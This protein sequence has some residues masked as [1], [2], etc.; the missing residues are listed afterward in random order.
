MSVILGD[1]NIE[2][3]YVGSDDV[4][5]IYKGN[6]LI[7]DFTLTVPNEP[8]NVSINVEDIA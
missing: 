2:Q 8:T 1:Q 6:T 7:K 3:I 5:K 4:F